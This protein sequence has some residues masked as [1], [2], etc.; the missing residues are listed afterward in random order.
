MMKAS[1][2]VVVAIMLFLLSVAVWKQSGGSTPPIRDGR[3]NPV[4][5]SIASLESVELGGMEQWVLIR[6]TDVSNPVL[7]W[8]HGGP[9][10]AQ[11]PVACHF[12]GALE[13]GFVV[14][15]WDQRGAGKSNPPSFDEQTMTLEQ[16][17]NDAHEL[18]QYLKDR[19]G[20]EKI[21]L[22]GHSWGAQLGL[23]LARAYPDDYYAYVGVSQVV[24]PLRGHEIAH[25]WLAP[26][27]VEKGRPKD[28]SRL[29]ELGPPPFTDHREYVSFAQLVNAYGGN[30]DV[31]MGTLARIA[32]RAPE[33]RLSDYPA[34]VRGANRGSGPMWEPLLAFN[35]FAD[36]PQLPLPVYFFNGRYD[37]NT[38]LHLAQEYFEMLEAPAGKQLVIF[39]ESAH[40]P[41]MREPDRFNA[42]M[43]RVRQNTAL[44]HRPAA[45]V[46]SAS[47]TGDVCDR[48]RFSVA[49]NP[50]GRKSRH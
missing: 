30:M 25:A 33:Y 27:V 19:F 22:V 47:A 31:G 15:H 21:Y 16:F 9:G 1:R 20:Q 4:P 34:W 14:V 32:L 12:N 2:I 6:G 7:L 10:A 43:A 23:K 44:S 26:R 45:T 41:F 3:G 13:A 35:A 36:V 29:E 18:T 46:R 38:P 42:E 49:E 48:G 17:I 24:D 28:R 40:T 50:G 5:G 37:Y 11:I 8:L 39:E